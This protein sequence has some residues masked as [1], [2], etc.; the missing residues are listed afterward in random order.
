MSDV[1]PAIYSLRLANARPGSI[2]IFPRIDGHLFGLVTDEAIK[3]DCRSVVILNLNS[4]GYPSVIFAQS[5]NEMCLCYPDAC[6][7]ELSNNES[8]IDV[9]GRWWRACGVVVSTENEILIRAFPASRPGGF[10]HVNIRTGAVFS[11]DLPN[12]VATF[13][14]WSLW[15]RDPL[16]E[17]SI[18]I[19]DFD[20]HK[21]AQAG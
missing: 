12:F 3:E 9:S 2:V 13:G 14:V 5:W 16:R 20:I 6:R 17:R 10:R 4:P 1:F 18:K 7:F 19:F 8:D 15:L 11:G 21:Q